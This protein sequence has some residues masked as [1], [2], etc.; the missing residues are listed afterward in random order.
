MS[1]WRAVEA[2]DLPPSVDDLVQPSLAEPG[3]RRQ[4]GLADP[5]VLLDKAQQGGS[6]ASLE[7][8]T[9]LGPAPHARRHRYRAISIRHLTAR[10]HLT[11]RYPP[12]DR[13]ATS[14]SATVGTDGQGRLGEGTD[15]DDDDGSGAGRPI[16]GT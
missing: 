16:G 14:G 6:V 13:T 7:N 4:P 11:V 2:C 9:E 12:G 15:H 1:T 10:L 5:G 3:R 8:I